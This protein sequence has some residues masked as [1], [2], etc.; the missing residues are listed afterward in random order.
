MPLASPVATQRVKLLDA[1]VSP[2][3]P[4]TFSEEEDTVPEAR[5]S[6]K[7]EL[8]RTFLPAKPPAQEDEPFATLPEAEQRTKVAAAE[9]RMP[10]TK[11]PVI[12]LPVALPVAAQSVKTAGRPT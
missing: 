9:S 7:A 8:S 3:K 11:P 4:P 2:M 5:Q 6:M 1:V 12:S 10:P